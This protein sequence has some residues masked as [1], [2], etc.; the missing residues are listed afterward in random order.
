M[1]NPNVQPIYPKN[2]IYWKARLL[3]QVTPR[4]ITTE[5]PLLLGTA[6]DNGCLIHAIDARHHGDNVAT[7]VRLYTQYPDD[8]VYYLENELSLTAVTAS[9]NT[10]AIAPIS[11]TLPAILPASNTGMHLEGGVSL[12]CSLG[13]AV[14]T[15]I[16]VTVRGGDY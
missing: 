3:A 10:T 8:T 15:G 6:G 9:N 16:I 5:T 11:F 14:A 12:Y 2:I 7:V 4:N 1:A 13:T